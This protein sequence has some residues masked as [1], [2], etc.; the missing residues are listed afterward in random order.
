MT[1]PNNPAFHQGKCGKDGT[2]LLSG[3]VATGITKREL[4]AAMAMVGRL[5][6]TLPIPS[7]TTIYGLSVSDAD[8]LI[9]ELNQAEAE[10]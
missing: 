9:L 1:N 3:E 6:N 2:Y 8:K 10:R 4:I 7:G 5:A